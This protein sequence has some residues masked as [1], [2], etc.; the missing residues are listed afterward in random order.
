MRIP[1]PVI[2]DE[3]EI[4]DSRFKE[5]VQSPV[6]MLN[7][8]TSFIVKRK[9]KQMRPMFVLLTAKVAGGI[10]DATYRAASLVELV[11]TASLVHD[12]VVDESMER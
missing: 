11:H 10:T 3:L 9:G 2:A 6:P 8:I 1:P 4:F 12:D 7:R 5:A